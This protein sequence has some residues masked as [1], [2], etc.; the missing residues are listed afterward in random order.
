MKPATAVAIFLAG[1]ICGVL[2]TGKTQDW[3]VATI[4]SQHLNGEQYCEFNPGAGVELSTNDLEVRTLVGAYRNSLCGRWSVYAGKSYLPFYLRSANLRLGG[5]AMLITG[6]ESTLTLGAAF[7]LSYEGE[8]YGANLVWFP[9]KKGDFTAG[10][11][12]LQAKFRW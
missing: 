7:V 11:V 6:Y 10:V 3:A 2:G 1:L 4:G 8:K 9:S 5:A 12:A